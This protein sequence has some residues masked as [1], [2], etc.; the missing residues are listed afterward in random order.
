[1]LKTIETE[2]RASKRRTEDNEALL[3][4]VILFPCFFV[5]AVCRRLLAAALPGTDGKCRRLSCFEDAKRST[6]SVIPYTM[7]R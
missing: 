7:M 2:S 3:F 5:A 1:M 6:Y 4:V